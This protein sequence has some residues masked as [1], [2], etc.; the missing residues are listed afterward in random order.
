MT[1]DMGIW[2][3]ETKQG[4]KY[5]EFKPRRNW[6]LEDGVFVGPRLWVDDREIMEGWRVFKDG[7]LQINRV[8][9]DEIS[10][11]ELRSIR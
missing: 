11:A 1:F 9:E 6:T 4:G 10:Q 7:H 2:R 5:R 3:I 8:A